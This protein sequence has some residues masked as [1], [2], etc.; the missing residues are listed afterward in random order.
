MQKSTRS[1]SVKRIISSDYATGFFTYAFFISWAMYFIVWILNLSFMG[2]STTFEKVAILITCIGILVF[3]WRLHFFKTLYN[4][5]V[6]T[7]GT[8]TFLGYFSKGNRI[9]YAYAFKNKQY[10][11]GNGL[12]PQ[13][14]KENNYNLGDEI[15]LLVDPKKPKKAVIKDIYF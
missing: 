12:S 3:V 10:S 9:E 15:L 5:G 14:I 8:I 4:H 1:F 6:E 7:T 13:F 2:G 11:S